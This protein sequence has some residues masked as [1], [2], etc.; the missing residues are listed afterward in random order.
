MTTT[1]LEQEADLGPEQADERSWGSPAQWDSVEY[2]LT[3]WREQAAERVAEFVAMG[4]MTMKPARAARLMG[5]DERTIYRWKR[6]AR[7]AG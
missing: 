7:E 6:R 5:V 1:E 2:A 3:C 4:G